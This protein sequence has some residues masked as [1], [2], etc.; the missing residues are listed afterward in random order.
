MSKPAPDHGWKK[1]EELREELRRVETYLNA[2]RF[3][4]KQKGIEIEAYKKE[5]W[6]SKRA[7]ARR[8]RKIVV[9]ADAAEKV[10]E[11]DDDNRFVRKA[12]EDLGFRVTP[13]PE[14]VQ[15]E[16]DDRKKK[17]ERLSQLVRRTSNQLL[18]AAAVGYTA[19][20]EFYREE[21]H[22]IQ[23]Y[24]S[25]L[26]PRRNGKVLARDRG[27]VVVE[28]EEGEGE[29]GEQPAGVANLATMTQTVVEVDD[30]GV[31]EDFDFDD[32]PTRIQ[33]TATNMMNKAMEETRES[34]GRRLGDWIDKVASDLLGMS[35]DSTV[36][37]SHSD[38]EDDND[39][40]STAATSL[41]SS[42]SFRRSAA[43]APVSAPTT[44]AAT[45]APTSLS[46][47]S[48]VYAP[49]T[50]SSFSS[51]NSVSTPTAPS[52]FSSSW[53]SVSVPMSA[54]AATSTSSS[55]S[56]PAKP[57]APA[58]ATAKPPPPPPPPVPSIRVQ[59]PDSDASDEY[60]G[61]T[62]VSSDKLSG[63]ALVDSQQDEADGVGT[64]PAPEDPMA[65]A[66]R[67]LRMRRQQVN[68]VR[69]TRTRNAPRGSASCE[70]YDN[71]LGPSGRLPNRPR[72]PNRNI[73]DPR[74]WRILTD[75]NDGQRVRNVPLVKR[76]KQ[77]DPCIETGWITWKEQQRRFPSLKRRLHLHD[78]SPEGAAVWIPE[79]DQI[80]V[81][82]PINRIVAENSTVERRPMKLNPITLHALARYVPTE[83]AM[84][85]S[86][87]PV[88]LPDNP[89]TD[90]KTRPMSSAR[91]WAG[92]HRVKKTQKKKSQKKGTVQREKQGTMQQEKQ[93][94]MQRE[95]KGT[96]QREKKVH[97]AASTAGAAYAGYVAPDNNN[98]H[99]SVLSTSKKTPSLTPMD[100]GSA[101][102]S[103]TVAEVHY[104]LK[105][106]KTTSISYP[107]LPEAT[108]FYAAPKSPA[109]PPTP[110]PYQTS[111]PDT[112]T[113][114]L[115][116]NPFPGIPQFPETPRS[117][118]SVEFV[119]DSAPKKADKTYTDPTPT[120]RPR[121]RK[122]PANLD[123]GT[124]YPTP[125]P[126]S[127]FSKRLRMPSGQVGSD[128]EK[129][130]ATSATSSQ[131]FS[132]TAVNPPQTAAIS[133]A[134]PFNP[135][136]LPHNEYPL[137]AYD[138]EELSTRHPALMRDYKE[139]RDE[140][141]TA[142]R[143]LRS[144]LRG[145]LS[146]DVLRP[147]QEHV[148]ELEQRFH[149]VERMVKSVI[150]EE[151]VG[152]HEE[153][154]SVQ[155]FAYPAPPNLATQSQS[156][157][158]GLRQKG[159]SGNGVDYDAMTGSLGKVGRFME[160]DR[161]RVIRPKRDSGRVVKEKRVETRKI[162]EKERAKKSVR[163]D[164]GPNDV[165]LFEAQRAVGRFDG[166]RARRGVFR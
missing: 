16:R 99:S 53:S 20:D 31:D 132:S 64:R 19:H 155:D 165:M 135:P 15:E 86:V 38:S 128:S 153:A 41:G 47:W 90:T 143:R 22:E 23:D 89:T 147:L 105:S 8:E 30:G 137:T 149:D 63:T 76:T 56:A 110:F 21:Q 156:A 109:A 121:E 14:L 62:L 145:N 70:N 146:D 59:R 57:P 94:T 133:Q 158:P 79:R 65:A 52:S 101:P 68:A 96:M 67:Y 159:V 120:S 46:S 18:L 103:P 123:L 35:D 40:A 12:R 3:L 28:E 85:H 157:H 161:E 164:E 97:F 129:E 13:E 42:G 5:G 102:P 26:R 98:K 142:D 95:Q 119:L 39:D 150:T 154:S 34:K 114:A 71:G 111:F 17:R 2:A 163:F 106:P 54:T 43:P 78:V 83:H 130:N 51:W 24:A 117:A 7:R 50:P 166:T 4:L 122:R 88:Q 113:V 87:D 69:P 55:S 72:R 61:T 134:H 36:V 100:F 80:E 138:D 49:T 151:T 144:Q 1:E 116:N 131:S 25:R 92:K 58:A 107:E 81:W 140:L 127:P 27:G 9:E 32:F 33:I 139:A 37:N 75:Q 148:A 82:D 108:A 84:D 125:T 66:R 160:Q 126:S 124:A 152:K 6:V 48:S 44:T 91:T 112:P 73:Y 115:Y 29:G 60:S 77:P 136:T 104:P 141:R 45:A 162:G 74:K 93:A 11:L 10:Q 118:D